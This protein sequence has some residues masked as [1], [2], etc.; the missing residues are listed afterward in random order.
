M[1]KIFIS[2]CATAIISMA[3][4]QVQ[5]PQPSPTQYIKQD[6]GMASIELTYSRPSVKGRAI[7]GSL[8]P[9]DAVW[10]TGANA[11]TK[12]RFNDPVEINGKKVDT[13]TYALYTIPKKDGDWTFILNKGTANWGSTGYKESDDVLRTT[14][15]TSKNAQPVET[16]TMQ[17]ANVKAESCVLKIKWENYALEIPI[18]TNIKDRLRGQFETALQ[19]E[20]KPFWQAAQFYNEYDK[21]YPKALEMINSALAAQKTPA[22]YMVYYKATI[23][24]NAGNKKEAVATAQ[25]ALQ[26]AKEAKEAGYIFLSEKLLNELK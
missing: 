24:K 4:A 6:F 7:F 19:S 23:L 22:Y 5:M 9:W 16:L 11:V 15:K 3:Q 2:V 25:Q 21:N 17:F 1:K 12:I 13:G 10:R 18:T 26:L 8:E 20:K 14:V